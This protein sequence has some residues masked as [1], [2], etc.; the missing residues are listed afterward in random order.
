MNSYN[1]FHDLIYDGLTHLQ[2]GKIGEYWF[3]LILTLK[4]FDTYTSEVDDKGIDFIVRVNDNRHVDIQVK[5]IRREKTSYVFVSK[6]A[7]ENQLRENLYLGL[8][9]LQNGTLPQ[10][11]MIPSTAWL[12][13]SALFRNRDYMELGQKSKPEWGL[14]LSAK[15]MPLLDQFRIENQLGGLRPT[16][17]EN[18]GTVVSEEELEI[19]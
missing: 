5:T 17:P 4:G 10:T 14:N 7:W 9:I 1:L 11:Y 15:N 2:V 6:N 12:E 16:D 3:K 13:E 19:S 18:P 8:V